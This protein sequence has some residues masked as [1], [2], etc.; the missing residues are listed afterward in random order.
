MSGQLC[1]HCFRVKGEYEVCPWC[2]HTQDEEEYQACQL[3]PGTMLKG[4]YIIGTALGI[5]GFGITYK[6]YDRMLSIVVAIKEFFPAGL[7]NRGAG[8]TEVG[9]FSGEKQ[10][11]FDRLL[12]RFQEEAQNMAKFSRE[13]DIV[14]IYD[15]VEANKTAYIIMEYVDGVLLKDR[16]KQEGKME[17]TEATAYI[18][19]ILNALQKIHYQGLVHKDVSPD[20][21]FLMEDGK[22]KLMDFGAAR[23]QGTKTDEQTDA[24]VK[25]GYTPPEQYQSGSGQ[26]SFMDIYAVGAV[27]YEMVT[28]E[29]PQDAMDRLMEDGL[30][31]PSERGADWDA[32]LDRIVMKAMAVDPRLRFQTAEKFRDAIL[33][34]KKVDLPEEEMRKRKIRKWAVGIGTAMTAAVSLTAFLLSQT[35]FSGRGKIDV[36]S[37]Q[38]D[39]IQV[40]IEARGGIDT[41]ALAEAFQEEMGKECPQVSVEVETVPAEDYEERL[42]LAIEEKNLPDV[43][44][45]DYLPEGQEAEEV[46]ADLSPLLRT[47][48]LEQYMFS[49]RWEKTRYEMPTAM[50]PGIVYV[51]ENK[52]DEIPKSYDKEEI[53]AEGKKLRYGWEA[54]PYSEFQEDTAEAGLIAGDLSIM[55]GVKAATVDEIPPI[56]FA[57]VPIVEGGKLVESCCHCYGVRANAGKNKENAAMFAISLLL[58]DR[59]QSIAYMDNDEG[60]PINKAAYED[61]KE[62]RMTTYLSF[63]KEYGEEDIAVKDE[64]IYEYIGDGEE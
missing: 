47:L 23:L 6:A 19:A 57:A 37:I 59:L 26:G 60:I 14:N 63:L 17:P 45:A 5:G 40:W 62:Y 12:K 49:E 41:E 55:E 48:D 4:R 38:E 51:N 46:C 13:S 29:K 25:V 11:E 56:D 50:Q 18:V 24:I 20:N 9:I 54:D 44:C 21:I 58:N 34:K 36:G 15:Y 42:S 32:R 27:Y 3:R 30:Q 43:F 8:E 33:G 7:V 35:V 28:G 10:E 52:C 22:I 1:F 53:L 2:G 39:A 64:G 31:A 16:M 61:Y